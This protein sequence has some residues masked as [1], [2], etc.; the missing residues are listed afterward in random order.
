LGWFG[1]KGLQNG[2]SLEV[3]VTFCMGAGCLFVGALHPEFGCILVEKGCKQDAKL[4]KNV[5][6]VC[7][8]PY[9]FHRFSV[10]LACFLSEICV[11]CVIYTCWGI[12]DF[13]WVKC[14][15]FTQPT[16]ATETEE[17]YFKIAFGYLIWR[18]SDCFATAIIT[19]SK[20]FWLAIVYVT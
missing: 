12:G 19:N 10:C 6:K 15:N 4:Q 1:D 13:C 2:C 16:L 5:K 7:S 3:N 14:I 8:K 20:D 11:T 17:K 18:W 9:V